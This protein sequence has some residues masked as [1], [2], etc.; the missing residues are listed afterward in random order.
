MPGNSK[1]CIRVYAQPVRT[2]GGKVLVK[3]IKGNVTS[4]DVTNLNSG[5]KY[6]FFVNAYMSYLATEDGNEVYVEGKTNS[7]TFGSF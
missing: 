1:P 4:I 2:G 3:S 6:K 7:E 5:V